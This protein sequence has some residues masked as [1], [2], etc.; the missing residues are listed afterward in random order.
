LIV[1]FAGL[2]FGVDTAVVSGAISMVKATFGLDADWEGWVVSSAVLGCIVGTAASGW[3]ADRFGRRVIL[4]LAGV[5]FL[6]STVTSAVPPSAL[7]LVLARIVG[8]LGIGIASVVGPLYIA[9]VSLPRLRGRMIAVYQLAITV[10]ILMAF[11]S[12]ALVFRFGARIAGDVRFLRWLLVDQMW[13]GMLGA[14]ALPSL[15][16]VLLILLVPESP[17]WLLKKGRE[18]EASRVLA[19]LLGTRDVRQELSVISRSLTAGAGSLA[20]LFS[21]RLR[22]PLVI[23]VLMT[24]FGNLSGI[25]VI[26]YYSPKLLET[27]GA[28][29]EGAM[30]GTVVIGVMN[31][32]FTL[33]AIALVDRAGRRPLLLVGV[34]GCAAA[35]NTAALLFALRIESG[36]GLLIPLLAHVACFAFSYGAIGWIVISE[37]FPTRIRGRA[38]GFVT[39]FGW[40]T[41]FLISQ[42]LPRLLETL[43]GAGVFGIYGGATAA[44]VVY[45]AVMVPETKGKTLEEIE[46]FWSVP[47]ASPFAHRR[48]SRVPGGRHGRDEPCPNEPGN[49][50]VHSPSP[51]NPKR[52]NHPL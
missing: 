18:A 19:R 3:L 20:E 27:A 30:N 17:R 39:M 31:I 2:L 21:P 50:T 25:N 38:A 23:G 32:L 45:I 6:V 9:E 26:M 51:V 22:R 40:G 33:V 35:L 42:S 44:A 36:L 43:G 13:R 46:R 7:V 34:S 28:A 8:G 1:G 41:G 24:I 16:F 15:L 47:A 12:N 48:L 10:G 37:L 29:P 49:L 14:C 52:T 4:R 5:L 11:A